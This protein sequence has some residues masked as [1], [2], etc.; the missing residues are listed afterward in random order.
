MIVDWAF[1]V[2]FFRYDAVYRFFCK[3]K[4]A[5]E[6]R[7]SDWCS[8]VCSSDLAI[9]KVGSAESAVPGPVTE[10]QSVSKGSGSATAGGDSRAPAT[11]TS[12]HISRI[13]TIR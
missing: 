5:Y 13:A 12:T 7:I 6:M 8:Y 1:Q 4:T 11:A 10:W 9:G 2:F 3:Q